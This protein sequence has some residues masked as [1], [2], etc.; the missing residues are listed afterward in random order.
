MTL[1]YAHVNMWDNHRLSPL[2]GNKPT[3]TLAGIGIYPPW[4]KPAS[5]RHRL[6][7]PLRH[8]CCA[9][10]R[11]PRRW[12]LGI[13]DGLRVIKTFVRDDLDEAVTTRAGWGMI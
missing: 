9:S 8:A 3:F 2:A 12:R 10:P 11:L 4:S 7:R 13:A 5:V 6:T 1:G